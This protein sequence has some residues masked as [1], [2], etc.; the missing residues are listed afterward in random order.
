MELDGIGNE[1]GKVNGSWVDI[2]FNR[3]VMQE[4]IEPE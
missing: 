4:P 3:I 2:A 1:N